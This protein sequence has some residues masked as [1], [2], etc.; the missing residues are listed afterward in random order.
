MATPWW[1]R[2]R[3]T[4]TR[5]VALVATAVAVLGWL[6]QPRPPASADDEIYDASGELHVRVPTPWL[7]QMQ[8]NGWSPRELGLPGGHEP[9][10]LVATDLDAWSDARQSVSG[11]F[12]GLFVSDGQ[13][14]T[15]TG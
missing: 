1:Q 14:P 12:A 2:Y 6:R 5:L 10:L 15:W 13:S 8:L 9:G 4:W 7:R 3:A 11:L